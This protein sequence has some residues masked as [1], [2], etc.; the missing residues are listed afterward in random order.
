MNDR[1]TRA[2]ALLQELVTMNARIAGAQYRQLWIIRELED[3]IDLAFD[4]YP[5]YLAYRCGMSLKWS[6]EFIRVARAL[7]SLPAIAKLF[8]EG[9]ITYS[10]VRIVTR[11]ATAETDAKYAKLAL[12]GPVHFLEDIVRA[13]KQILHVETQRLEARRYVDISTDDDG[14]IVIRARLAPDEGALFKKALDAAKIA[15]A[16]DACIALTHVATAAVEKLATG[17]D[18]ILHVESSEHICAVEGHACSRAT[19]E[20]LICQNP[21][22]RFAS[23]KQVRALR[24]I[25]AGFC[26]YPGCSH[27]RWLDAHHI[28][29]WENG[30]KTVIENLVLICDRHH[31]ELHEGGHSVVR[32]N[33]ELVFR[34]QHGLVIPRTPVVAA[35]ALDDRDLSAI[36]VADFEDLSPGEFFT[37]R[38]NREASID[39]LLQEPA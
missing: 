25:Q 22:R 36:P 30:G 28:V 23:D 8:E 34:N 17:A 4:T 37:D 6:Y 20:R 5:R 39:W 11:V 12:E 7:A 2:D 35:L 14:M 16:D 10:K 32:E 13:H 27:R 31:R 1:Q 38:E 15:G 33:G 21:H 18:K 24:Q 19:A 9:R 29:H 3:V 26:G